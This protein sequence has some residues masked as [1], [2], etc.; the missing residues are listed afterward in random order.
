MGEKGSRHHQVGPVTAF[1]HFFYTQIF[2][3]NLRDGFLT[4]N[5][6]LV[7]VLAIGSV[8]DFAGLKS[9][10]TCPGRHRQKKIIILAITC[11]R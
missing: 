4:A 7:S 6:L 10:R 1:L 8:N 5:P 2:T 11:G 9:V 3:Q